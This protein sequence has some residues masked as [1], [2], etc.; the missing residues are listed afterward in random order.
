MM[1]LYCYV[2]PAVFNNNAHVKSPSNLTKSRCIHTSKNRVHSVS[3]SQRSLIVFCDQQSDSNSSSTGRDFAS[4]GIRDEI[5]LSGRL[6][7]ETQKSSSL[8]IKEQ[9]IQ[10]G[11]DDMLD[12]FTKE[13]EEWNASFQP[14][15]QLISVTDDNGVRKI[16]LEAGRTSKVPSEG[17]VAKVHY[18]GRLGSD[19]GSENV[20]EIVEKSREHEEFDSSY[21][22]GQPFGVTIGAGKVIRGWDLVLRTM[23]PGEKSLVLIDSQYAYGTRGVPP[24]IPS[25]ASLEFEIELLA[26]EESEE[27]KRS[28]SSAGD[29]TVERRTMAD[30]NPETERTPDSISRAYAARMDSKLRD[31]EQGIKVPFWDRFY[32][33]SPFASQT[34]ERPP[35]WLNPNITFSIVFITTALAFWLVLESG[36]LHQGYVEPVD[37]SK[38]F[39]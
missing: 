36:A 20:E 1:T 26:I 37:V 32:F 19:N 15:N 12:P 39:E 24:V 25:G 17:V 9:S 3:S 2:F 31:E 13:E 4:E 38:I 16:I 33:I 22:R 21:S 27:Q 6:D 8:K 28:A 23:N 30:D 18:V 11:V 7:P 5:G 35:W 14:M 10:Y 29:N 34:G